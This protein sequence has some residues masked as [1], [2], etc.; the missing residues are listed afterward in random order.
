MFF[1]YF[2]AASDHLR[3]IGW[4][5][6]IIPGELVTERDIETVDRSTDHRMPSELRRLY[7]ELGD[8]FRF[9]PDDSPNSTVSGLS[10][11]HI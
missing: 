5:P 11:I 9:E 8:A 2:A 6:L 10:L 7:L 1:S 4:N 3:K